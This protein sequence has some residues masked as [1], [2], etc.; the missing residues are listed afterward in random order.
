MK[1]RWD[2][3]K[4]EQKKHRTSAYEGIPGKLSA[5]ARADSFL[6]RGGE[7]IVP[8]QSE[9]RPGV[10]SER[11]LGELLFALVAD[12]RTKGFDAER[13]LRAHLRELEAGESPT[14]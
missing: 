14:A 13:A 2:E 10:R 3:I 12:S 11:E 4:A 5:L 8:P 9:A 1:E 6:K 7:S